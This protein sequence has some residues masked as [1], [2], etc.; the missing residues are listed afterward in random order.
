MAS[1]SQI[2]PIGHSSWRIESAQ[3]YSLSKGSIES[4]LPLSN[5]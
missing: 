3:S 5:M 2:K 1:D 4:P